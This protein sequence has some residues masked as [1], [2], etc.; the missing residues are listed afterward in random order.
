MP[1]K[2]MTGSDWVGLMIGVLGFASGIIGI[3]AGRRVVNA[4]RKKAEAD[5]NLTDADAFDKFSDTLKKLQERNDT[6]YQEKVALETQLTEKTRLVETLTIRLEERDRQLAA[7]TKQLDLLRDMARQ[8][9]VTDTL[10]EQLD[11]TN[12]IIV[13]LQVAQKELSELLLEREK[14]YNVLFESTRNIDLKKPPKP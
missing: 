2:T 10:K 4:Q 12:A 1:G 8:A 13:N 9:P 6:L 14:A 7:N 3:L 11:A 5:T